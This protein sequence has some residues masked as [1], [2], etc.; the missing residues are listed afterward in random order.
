MSSNGYKNKAVKHT[1]SIRK[2]YMNEIVKYLL[3]NLIYAVKVNKVQDKKNILLVLDIGSEKNPSTLDIT[4]G[5]IGWTLENTIKQ[6]IY[7]T[8]ADTGNISD[9]VK[10]STIKYW[11]TDKETHSDKPD[12]IN[13]NDIFTPVLAK[14]IV[15][16]YCPS[17]ITIDLE[18]LITKVEFLNTLNT[19]IQKIKPENKVKYTYI[20]GDNS[21][22]EVNGHEIKLNRSYLKLELETVS[23]VDEVAD[24]LEELEV[25]Q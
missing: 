1:E 22:L 14:N 17:E 11:K 18:E 20:H 23:P 25:V 8:S 12:I 10:C 16:T 7:V 6:Y 19:Y 9:F 21:S 2:K 24:V 4:K 5:K 3:N 13:S 15:V